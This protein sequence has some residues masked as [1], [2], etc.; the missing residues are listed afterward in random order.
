MNFNKSQKRV[1][2]QINRFLN[3]SKSHMLIMGA[4]GTGK[5]TVVSEAFKKRKNFRVAFATFTNKAVKM[6]K[7]KT[8]YPCC[9]LH[10]LLKLELR[11][12]EKETD[13]MFKFNVSDIS[14]LIDYNVV[15]VDE[16]SVIGKEMYG[17]FIQTLNYLKLAGSNIKFIFIGDHRQL[18]PVGESVFPVFKHA[19]EEKWPV[20]HLLKV[21]RSGNKQ[22][23]DLNN[24]MVLIYELVKSHPKKFRKKYPYNIIDNKW[25]AESY[26]SFIKSYFSER[27]KTDEVVIITYSRANCEKINNVIQ[28]EIDLEAK[29]E[30][31]TAKYNIGDRCTITRPT[32]AAYYKT[33]TNDD[34]PTYV[35]SYSTDNMIY[36]GELMDIID[37]KDI[38]IITNLNKL[39]YIV[40]SFDAQLLTVHPI[41]NEESIQI[42]H[43]DKTQITA[44]KRRIY[45]IERKEKYLEYMQSYCNIFPIVV[46]GYCITLYKT[47]GSEY[48]SVL[49]NLN[50]IYW[51]L[52][53]ST[54]RMLYRATYTACSRAKKNLILNYY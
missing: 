23:L 9:T 8:D 13:L 33:Q 22:M 21:M 12:L 20:C 11:F 53:S 5:T 51:S 15:V 26:D 31:N 28:S 4:G 29:R 43:V 52:K 25:F 18:P 38:K 54:E 2:N 48:D 45:K 24:H 16:C 14:Y 35:V 46:R 10:K 34:V 39:D 41:N 49:V 6:L 37:T 17:Y 7:Q 40:D 30:T 19:I 36:N 42:V 1:I 47:Q 27:K 44:A 50:S 3:S 32:Y